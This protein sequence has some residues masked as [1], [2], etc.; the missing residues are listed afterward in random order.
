MKDASNF[1]KNLKLMLITYNVRYVGGMS[2]WPTPTAIESKFA[3][4]EV[5][6]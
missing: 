4:V 5:E 6:L 1:F 3:I 2:Y